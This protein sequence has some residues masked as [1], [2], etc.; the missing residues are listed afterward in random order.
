MTSNDFKERSPGRWS[1]C[2]AAGTVAA[3]LVLASLPNRWISPARELARETLRPG[4]LAVASMRD[5][6]QS[7]GT[8]VREVF[9][10]AER[11]AQ[12]ESDLR[13]ANAENER[14]RAALVAARASLAKEQLLARTRMTTSE[15][16]TRNA[17]IET[18]V[19]GTQA[20]AFLERRGIIEAGRTHG[21][22]PGNLVVDATAQS[23]D[24]GQD[25]GAESGDYLLAGRGVWGRIVDVGPHTATAR[26]VHGAGYRDLVRL[27]HGQDDN[28]HWGP[29]GILEGTGERL[30]RIRYIDTT[31]P[32]SVGDLVY[33][34]PHQSGTDEPLVYG[35]VVRAQRA[36]ESAHWDVWMEP[37][38]AGTAPERLAV[39]TARVNPRRLANAAESNHVAL[40]VDEVEAESRA[41]GP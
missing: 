5:R 6:V 15:P 20:R 21:V 26:R 7:F 16:L 22:E 38:A 35:R 9:S 29:Q 30:C 34:A 40:N 1:A 37:A 23:V 12:S 10:R 8:P 11:L 24:V 2:A 14:L 41:L 4:Q 19:L 27:S 25:L 36:A 33:A 31:E 13:E 28:P 32:V 18:R 17:L 39:L 3:A